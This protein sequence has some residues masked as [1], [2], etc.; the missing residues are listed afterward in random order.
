MTSHTMHFPPPSEG[1]GQGGGDRAA[2]PSPELFF[3]SRCERGLDR[4]TNRID[5]LEDVL[6]PETD[7]VKPRTFKPIGPTRIVRNGRSMLPTIK[8]HD[9]VSLKADKVDNIG[10]QG[11]LTPES[12]AAELAFAQ[13]IP[14]SSFRRRRFGAQPF[15]MFG[16]HA[17]CLTFGLPAASPPTLTLPL[18]GGGKRFFSRQGGATS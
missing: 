16:R 6:V 4:I 8:L 1:E 14:E 15:G 13:A 18:K 7:D 2:V 5:V 9:E 12:M 11:V 10:A 17:P 3:L